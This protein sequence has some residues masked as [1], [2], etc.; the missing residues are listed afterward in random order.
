MNYYDR[1]FVTGCDSNT[2]WQLKWFHNNFLEHNKE[3]PLVF[4]DFGVSEDMKQWIEEESS[5][6]ETVDVPKQKINGWFLKPKTLK[7]VNAKHLCWIDTDCHVLDNIED[8]W[9]HCEPNKLCMTK[10]RPWTKRQGQ[11]WYNSGVV[12]II[13]KPVILDKW[14]SECIKR[15]TEG[16]VTGTGDQEILHYLLGSPLGQIQHICEMPNIYNWLR[17]DFIDGL[18]SPNKRVVHWTGSKG[19][20]KIMEM[21]SNE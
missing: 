11:T 18:D 7:L 17:I 3:V 14:I 5:F 21:I 4:A 8:I 16:M 13:N 6:V 19:N 10:D 15:A 1:A 12:A 9:N 2:E 20:E